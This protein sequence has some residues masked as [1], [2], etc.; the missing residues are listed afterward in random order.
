MIHLA[1]DDFG[2]SLS[3]LFV[4]SI[5]QLMAANNESSEI[6]MLLLNV[7]TEFTRKWSNVAGSQEVKFDRNGFIEYLLKNIE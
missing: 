1:P 7:V 5:V 3:D 6:E 2:H 4:E